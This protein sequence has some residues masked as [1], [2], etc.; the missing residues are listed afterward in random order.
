[1]KKSSGNSF[2]NGARLVSAHLSTTLVNDTQKDE[3]ITPPSGKRWEVLSIYI[4]NGDTVARNTIVELRKAGT[5]STSL[6]I[7]KG[8][9]S[10]SSGETDVGPTMG[11][12]EESGRDIFIESGDGNEIHFLWEAGGASGGGTANY[13]YI[14]LETDI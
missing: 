9:G 11:N 13:G 10:A 4:H 12:T 7:I 8:F 3:V 14:V 2:R 6:N 5:P 1:M